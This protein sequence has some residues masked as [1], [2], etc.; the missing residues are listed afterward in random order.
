M[1]TLVLGG[2]GFIGSWIVQTLLERGHKAVVLAHAR[3]DLDERATLVTGD[4]RDRAAMMRA[5]D[6][7]EGVI[8]A[9]AYYPL[10]SIHRD[11]QMARAVDELH[12]M[13]NAARECGVARFVFTSTP[14]VMNTDPLALRWSTYHAIKRRLHDE[15]LRA[16]GEG[17]PGVIAVPA[18]CFGPGDRKPTTGRV[19]VEIASRRLRFILEGK[20][21]AVDVRDA[22]R[23]EVIML[24]RAE[25]GSVY[26]LSSWN[27]RYTEFARRV[28]QIARVP[29]PTVPVP[30]WPAK[31]AAIVGE[32]IQYHAGAPSPLL[33]QSGL[34]LIHF[35]AH[36]DS[37]R[38]R[39]DLEFA[40]RPIDETI[41]DTLVWFRRH[42]YL[43][44][45][46]RGRISVQHL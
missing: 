45:F 27:G 23:A 19:I 41:L 31:V 18:A 7:C 44:A 29:V 10:Y 22:A 15:V 46:R 33:P 26:P 1:N 16:I 37:G 11:A 32:V 30:Y 25:A 12:V 21:S 2:T 39:H 20:M 3:G 24:E 34:D 43:R 5:M 9:G 4:F 17:L 8:C 35:G 36:L 6:G 28:A 40:P 38:A 14:S 42:N 13:L